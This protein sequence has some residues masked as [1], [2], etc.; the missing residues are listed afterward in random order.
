VPCGCCGEC[1]SVRYPLIIPEESFSPVYPAVLC[2]AVW[3][4]D[5]CLAG[6]LYFY[7]G[8]G[9][10]AEISIF[11]TFQSERDINLAWFDGVK[12]GY[13]KIHNGFCCNRPCR[14]NLF[15]FFFSG[16]RKKNQLSYQHPTGQIAMKFHE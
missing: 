15:W 6:H 9:K 16:L 5:L 8:R 1:R 7:E 2:R 3:L 10:Y 12:T 4:I 11:K 13:T 14:G